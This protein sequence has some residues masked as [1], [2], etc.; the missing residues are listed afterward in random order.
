M[1]Q[2]HR[3][4]TSRT[5]LLPTSRTA[6]GQERS[7]LT[8]LRAVAP[9]RRLTA[10]EGGIVAELQA[11][12][13]L[14]LAGS[15]SPPIPSELITDLPRIAV[16]QDPDLPVSGSAIWVAGRW[17]LSINSSEPW[18]RQ[19]F[20]LAHELKHVID[21]R[22]VDV[23]YAGDGEAERAA[24]HFAAALL[25]P[26]RAVLSEWTSGNQRLSTISTVFEVSPR[27]MARRLQHLGLRPSD[28]HRQEDPTR[29]Q[30]AGRRHYQRARP[31]APIG[32][33]A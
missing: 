32:G 20:S 13:L 4:L 16:R 12:R 30:R 6:R 9:R 15:P 17:L 7:V 8:I 21:H 33:N 29:P 22:H 31:A 27:A 2:Q 28:L 10:L 23:L 26:K 5:A 1:N 18:T 11:N 14:E 25:M 24:E 3:C 19:R